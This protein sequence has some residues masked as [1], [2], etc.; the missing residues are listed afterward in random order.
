MKAKREG[1]RRLSH[2]LIAEAHL[3]M[4][5]K[6][7]E[8]RDGLLYFRNRVMVPFDSDLRQQVIQQFHDT[9]VT[10]HG[11]KWWSANTSTRHL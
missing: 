7:C 4:E 1:Q 5:L 3:K 11:G 8:I 9:P 6:D 10:G 2:S